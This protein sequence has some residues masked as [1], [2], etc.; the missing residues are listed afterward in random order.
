VVACDVLRGEQDE[1]GEKSDTIEREGTIGSVKDEIR[2][3]A[4]LSINM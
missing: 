1:R 2:S 4:N 3:R